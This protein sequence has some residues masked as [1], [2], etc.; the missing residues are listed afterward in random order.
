MN[1]SIHEAIEAVCPAKHN[2]NILCIQALLF[3]KAE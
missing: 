2:Q 3:P 1:V